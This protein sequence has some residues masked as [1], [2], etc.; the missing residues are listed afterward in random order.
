MNNAIQNGGFDPSWFGKG[1]YWLTDLVQNR[2]DPAVVTTRKGSIG[3]PTT[4]LLS[5]EWLNHK[6]IDFVDVSRWNVN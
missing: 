5:L 3:W 6:N 1:E 2:T 4:R